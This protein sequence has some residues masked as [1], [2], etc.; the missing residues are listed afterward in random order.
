MDKKL[1]SS[2]NKDQEKY[3]NIE[4][5]GN[6]V[7][8]KLAELAPSIGNMIPGMV[9]SSVNPVLGATYFTASSGGSY[10]DDA[11]ERGMTDEQAFSYGTMMGIMEGITEGVT[12]GNFKKQVQQ[13]I[14]L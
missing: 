5:Q 11:K 7:S 14:V 10:I 4:N 3:K 12:V 2:I 6:S 8:K 1:Q 9:A 13:L